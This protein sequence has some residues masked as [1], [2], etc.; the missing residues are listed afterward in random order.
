MVNKQ[1][2]IAS[3]IIASAVIWAAVLIGCS[4]ALQGTE[5]YGSIKNILVGGIL[6]HIIIIWSPM[7]LLFKKDRSN[8]S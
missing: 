4:T 6:S 8:K 1:K 3:L 5:C 2:A 7:V